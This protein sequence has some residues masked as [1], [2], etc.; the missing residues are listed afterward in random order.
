MVKGDRLGAAKMTAAM[1]KTLPNGAAYY[2]QLDAAFK[3]ELAS[4]P[5]IAQNSGGMLTPQEVSQLRA[6][7]PL[8]KAHMGG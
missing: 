7:W 6:N 5:V 3:N 1:F 8:V 4:D 2:K